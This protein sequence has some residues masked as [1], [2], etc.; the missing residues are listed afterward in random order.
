MEGNEERESRPV[1]RGSKA[2]RPTSALS[3]SQFFDDECD[4]DECDEV[5]VVRG[6]EPMEEDDEDPDDY[7][8]QP[9]VLEYLDQWDMEL[10]DK[11]SLLRTAANYLTSK[12]KNANPEL[13]GKRLK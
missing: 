2:P 10:I 11:I 6:Q 12:A 1:F 13:K 4:V 8:D 7:D 9:D 5:D 3:A